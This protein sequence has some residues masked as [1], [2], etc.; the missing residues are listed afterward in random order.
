MENK[1]FFIHSEWKDF[2][3]I[4]ENNYHII[5]ESKNE[6]IGTFYF[7]DNNLIINWKK[8][9]GDD[10]FI[11]KDNI[12]YHKT[13]YDNLLEINIFNHIDKIFILYFIYL[14]ENYIFK[15]ND[16]DNIFK[17]NKYHNNLEIEWS[18]NIKEKYIKIINNYYSENY[19]KQLLINDNLSLKKE[20]Y[21]KIDNKYY[22]ENKKKICYRIFNYDNYL[23]KEYIFNNIFNLK[24]NSI[25]NQNYLN[26]KNIEKLNY[27]DSSLNLFDEIFN[28][29]INFEIP[30]KT[31][32]R[33]LSLVE[34]GYPPFG[35]GENWLLN[36]N[37]I[38]FEN[39]YDN[40][41]ICF[42]DPFKNKFFV[43]YNLIDLKYVKIIQMEKNLL[44][45]IKII[46]II[47][48]DLINHQGLDREY[49]MKISNILEI[50][51]LTGFCYWQNIVKFNNY[52]INI[53]ML[54]SKLEIT[55]EFINII[56][57]SYSYV[58]SD[59][60]NEIIYKLYNI[61]LDVI[62]T[63]SLKEDFL[64]ENQNIFDKKYVTLINCNYNKGG[65]L[66]EFLCNNLNPII[67][68]QIIYT[69]NDSNISSNF[70]QNLIDERN[71][72]NNI[73]I[74]Y[75]EKV[76]IKNIYQ[77]TKIL[78]VPSL[79]DETFCRVAYEGM[80]NKIPIL[81]TKNGNL[82][83]L[84]KDYAIFI[85]DLNKIE[86]LNNIEKLYNNIDNFKFKNN[87]FDIEPSVKLKLLNKINS[88][89]KSKYKLSNKNI[90]LIIPWADQGLGIQGRDYYITLKNLGYNPS[91]LSFKPYHSSEK[92][93]LL[94]TNSDEWKFENIFYSL[95]YRENLTYD[96]IVNYI[97]KFNIKK[98]IIIEATFINIFKIAFFLKILNIEIYLVVNIECI[99]LEEIFYHNIFNKIITNN[100]ESFNIINSIF[101]KNIEHLGFHLN[102][103]Y[104]KKIDKKFN[105]NLYKK[106]KFCCM[107]GLN[108]LS[109]KNI[110]LIIN[111][112]N[113]IFLEK[114]YNNWELNIY[115]QDIE[116][117][118][119][120]KHN[121]CQ[122]IH[123]FINNFSYNE[124]INKYLENDIFIHLGSHEGLGL[125]FYE[126]L[127][128]GLP[129]L[130]INWIPNNEIIKNNINGWLIDC[131][132][133][134]VNDN[135]NSIIN[136]A[137]IS[138]LKLKNKI[139]EILSNNNNTIKIIKNCINNKE[140]LFNKNKTL[141]ENNLLNILS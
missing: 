46:K 89:S 117:P 108:S 90:G 81:S 131:S 3:I 35:G 113:L 99:R 25:I 116:I 2:C 107:G 136:M 80:L 24:N 96:E 14:K 129:V 111:T 103:P 95:N 82:K 29:N 32:K 134:N 93:K 51:F 16:Y 97:H 79:C 31:K 130:T 8:W 121:K 70:V 12:F 13:F 86:W 87:N 115:I 66:V 34:W 123:F 120:L 132:F 76:N 15:I 91:V 62:E 11:K 138:E 125:G 101:N 57:N 10:I 4:D 23:N 53:N 1:Y 88:I 50:P 98:I 7:K 20:I 128:V 42:S 55:D 40:Y 124:V 36:L 77:N 45:I 105:K 119:S 27:N 43:D 21:I 41:L 110:N 65:Y 109:R 94:Q 56:Q 68:L 78:L 92:N 73:N 44:S 104:F 63:V 39:N 69:E 135:D 122:N 37:K 140:I 114:I 22:I 137:I 75:S 112:F 60:V 48:P 85:D 38:L 83:Y 141:F 61:N 84:L 30:L 47:N 102:Y 64:I 139:I 5:R 106:I 59:F 26:K 54:N 118:D 18:N 74:F 71:K 17:I 127:Y 33:C 133:N 52:P 49:F 126:S 100:N 67:P 58:A 28:L 9:L 6:E 72:T 19:I